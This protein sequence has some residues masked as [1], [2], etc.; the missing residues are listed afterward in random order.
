MA[1]VTGILATCDPQEIQQALAAQNID[2][3]TVRVVTKAAPSQEHTDSIID[4]V[5]VAQSMESN[6]FSDDMTHGTG[7]MS[8]SG[9]TNVP[10]IGGRSASLS[11]LSGGRTDR[12]DYLGGFAIPSDQ[13]ENYND[14]IGDGRCV[15]LCQ[16]DGDAAKIADSF[17]AA[18]LR[19]VRTF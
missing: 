10:G 2:A 5:F 17:R 9:G 19:N 15:V 8:D 1:L 13:I 16:T 4:F 3:S 14:A 11:S 7:M 6:D 18:G 12:F